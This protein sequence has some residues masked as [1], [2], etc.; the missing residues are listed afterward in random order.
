[1][2]GR[3]RTT[4]CKSRKSIKTRK[5]TVLLCVSYVEYSLS[6]NLYCSIRLIKAVTHIDI[7]RMSSNTQSENE[8]DLEKKIEEENKQEDESTEYPIAQFCHFLFNTTRRAM[9]VIFSP[10]DEFC[11]W[12]S[13]LGTY[14]RSAKWKGI[15]EK[16]GEN[17][18]SSR[19]RDLKKKT[20]PQIS[21]ESQEDQNATLCETRI[22]PK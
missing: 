3:V 2:I 8:K 7:I 19:S 9:G 21:Q 17:K 11:L 22:K 15:Q 4:R 1:M 12:M 5:C 14:E 10:D 6:Q 13:Q 20:K 18:D 16:Y